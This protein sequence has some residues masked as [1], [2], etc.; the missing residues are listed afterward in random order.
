MPR[1]LVTV[2]LCR[3]RSASG[4]SPS[5]AD[6]EECTHRNR[7]VDS[8]IAGV[9]RELN[10]TSTSAIERNAPSSSTSCKNVNRGK[11]CRN[12][13]TW[14]SGIHHAFTPHATY[15]RIFIYCPRY[16][17]SHAKTVSCQRLLL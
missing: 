16:F 14:C 15:T 6:A 3:V 17:R 11:R 9:R 1:E 10:E 13:V 8:T 12:T 7:F 2:I 4:S 5:T